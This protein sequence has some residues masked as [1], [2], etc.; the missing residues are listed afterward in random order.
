MFKTFRYPSHLKR[1]NVPPD[2]KEDIQVTRKIG[3][4]FYTLPTPIAGLALGIASLG[5]GLE[6]TLP[7]HNMGQII[8]A[9]VSMALGTLI[10]A[11]YILHPSLI[12]NELQHPVIGS[13]MPTLT[14]ALMLQSK[15][16]SLVSPQ[17]A[18]V[19]WLVAVCGHLA[20]LAGFLFFRVKSFHLHHMVPSWFVPF[21]GICIAAITVPGQQYYK[22]AYGLMVFGM[23][24][25][26]II[27]PIMIYRLIF[28]EKIEDSAKPTIAIM[29]APASLSLIAYLTLDKSPSLLLCSVL[30]GI[31][32]FMTCIIY[33]AFFK[34]LRLSFSPAFAAYTFPMV[35]G[36]TALYK[37]SNVLYSY[38]LARAYGEQLR[39]IAEIEMIIATVVIAYVCFRY[40]QYYTRAW[41][42]VMQ[43]QK[44]ASIDSHSINDSRSTGCA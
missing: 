39:M 42:N 18:V 36:S 20:L 19:L 33:F 15:S 30:L 44:I 32:M 26:A 24:N 28:S 25:Y 9:L 40:L 11:K 17:A 7:L 8:G 16:L 29:A 14:M 41:Y 5:A 13:V 3:K 43:A 31:A 1:G 35:V 38:P 4:L 22:I 6:S 23:V 34:L 2:D 10:I 37:A 12:K 27:L 21:V